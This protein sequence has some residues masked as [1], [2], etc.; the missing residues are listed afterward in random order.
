MPKKKDTNLVHRQ[1]PNS[2]TK[3]CLLGTL[4]RQVS[5]VCGTM[6]RVSAIRSRAKIAMARPHE[7]DMPPKRTE[8]SKNFYTLRYDTIRYDNLYLSKVQNSSALKMHK[9]NIIEIFK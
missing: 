6:V 7:P 9:T 5:R 1:E 4:R 3:L 8:I 2:Y